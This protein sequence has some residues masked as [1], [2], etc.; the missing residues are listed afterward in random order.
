MT[1]ET[2]PKPSKARTAGTLGIVAAVVLAIVLG[3]A[4]ER[5]CLSSEQAAL[6]QAAGISVRAWP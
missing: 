6:L 1:D 4:N 2:P 5:G 3:V